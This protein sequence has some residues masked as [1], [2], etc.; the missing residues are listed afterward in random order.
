MNDDAPWYHPAM[1]SRSVAR[2]F[3]AMSVGGTALG[4]V[5]LAVV[6]THAAPP[7]AAAAGPVLL[8][9]NAGIATGMMTDDSAVYWSTGGKLL[10]VD[11]VGGAMRT[12]QASTVT[13]MVNASGRLLFG[14]G[15]TVYGLLQP[16][17]ASPLKDFAVVAESTTVD[18]LYRS[19]APQ[20]CATRHYGSAMLTKIA[21]LDPSQPGTVTE[22]DFASAAVNLHVA[23]DGS[24]MYWSDDLEKTGTEGIYSATYAPTT[25]A[26]GTPTRLVSTPDHPTGLVADS[27]VLFWFEKA[28]LVSLST[29]TSPPVRTLLA[30]SVSGTSLVADATHVYWLT[31]AGISRVSR[32]GGGK[33][34]AVVAKKLD[35]Y[36]LDDSS[37]YWMTA[38]KLWK[39]PKG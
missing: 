4:A 5:L 36:T 21:C 6:A 29:T 30:G 11:K 15:A 24:R 3:P 35:A 17:K 33:V 19:V 10:A 16:P 7:K 1:S 25:K 8:A 37:V 9:S 39:Q 26:T 31:S 38:G 22:L 12:V 34:E 13:T 20:V 18:R 27:G 32:A 28:G 23:M 2:P 14:A